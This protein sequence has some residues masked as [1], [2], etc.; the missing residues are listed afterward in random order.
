MFEFDMLQ[1]NH[2][3]MPLYGHTHQSVS[4][5]FLEESYA[6]S[7]NLVATFG[8]QGSHVFNNAG[9]K[10]D[11]VKM[12]RAGV[13]YTN[14]TWTSKTFAFHNESYVDPY[15]INS[16]YV[17]NAYPENQVMN[18]IA[19]EVKYE[20]EA[21]LYEVFLSYSLVDNAPFS[22]ASGLLE[23]ATKV[24][25][26]TT[27]MVRYTYHYGTVDSL[28]LAYMYKHMDHKG[29]EKTYENH[30]VTL[31]HLHRFQNIDFFEEL[32]YDHDALYDANGYDISCGIQYHVSDDLTLRF[33]VQNLLDKAQKQYF[34]VVDAS[35]GV[36]LFGAPTY[37]RQFVLGFEWL[38]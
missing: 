7:P 37:E 21:S 20:N 4:S 12:G 23:T 29:A 2:T 3:D 24:S 33:K 5:L 35:T 31:R 6:F 11:F 32:F 25:P 10:D 27:G 13:T 30:R 17:A 9:V 1:M 15:L 8:V 19:Q 26:Y 16:F 36:M 22:N 18:T 38:F 34:P 14:D 28:S